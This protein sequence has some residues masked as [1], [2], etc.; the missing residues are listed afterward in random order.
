MRLGTVPI[1]K[2]E[3]VR[4]SVMYWGL[5][6]DRYGTR[7]GTALKISTGTVFGMVFW[8]KNGSVLRYGIPIPVPSPMSMS[9]IQ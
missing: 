8:P 2:V 9:Y 3:P 6:I 1:G 5:K 7:Y 4:F